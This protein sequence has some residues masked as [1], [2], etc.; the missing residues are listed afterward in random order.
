[1]SIKNK[2]KVVK[3]PSVKLYT[4]ANCPQCVKAKEFL[5]KNN[6]KFSEVNITG[7]KSVCKTIQANVGYIVAPVIKIGKDY[8]VGFE[9]GW[10]N[11]IFNI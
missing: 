3:R 8:K 9:E 4:M 10:Y 1:M 11:T 6:I 5:T 2:E 7:N